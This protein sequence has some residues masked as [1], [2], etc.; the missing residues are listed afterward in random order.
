[1]IY[2]NFDPLS[3]P[4]LHLIRLQSR[5]HP[6]HQRV[7]P[8]SQLPPCCDTIDDPFGSDDIWLPSSTIEQS[9]CLGPTQALG[10][11]DM[12]GVGR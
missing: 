10:C 3:P 2:V 7:L 5:A 4:Q 1:M 9:I 11:D 6:A 8:F 12:S